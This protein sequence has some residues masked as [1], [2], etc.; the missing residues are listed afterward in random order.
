VTVIVM[1]A[2]PTVTRKM[3]QAEVTTH[4][5]QVGRAV[6]RAAPTGTA[7]RSSDHRHERT[8]VPPAGGGMTRPV[9]AG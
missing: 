6:R 9:R 2:S 3:H 8:F 1:A 5:P 7:R 4:A